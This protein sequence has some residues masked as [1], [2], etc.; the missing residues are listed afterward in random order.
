M[1]LELE[2]HPD[3]NYCKYWRYFRLINVSVCIEREC[4][5][6]ACLCLCVLVFVLC[7]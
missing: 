7:V 5:D 3:L 4:K 2:I 6:L 1:N